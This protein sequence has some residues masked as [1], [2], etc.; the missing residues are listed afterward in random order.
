MQSQIYPR[1]SS[2]TSMKSHLDLL[3]PSRCKQFQLL[4]FYV[5][6][7]T[8]KRKFFGISKWTF[9]GEEKDDYLM[10][11]KATITNSNLKKIEQLLNSSQLLSMKI[12]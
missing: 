4:L 1:K 3:F 7:E 5:N 2:A 10:I 6:S 8:R 12:R 11:V 9:Q